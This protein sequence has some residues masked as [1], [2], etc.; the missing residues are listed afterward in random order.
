MV[1]SISIESVIRS[2]HSLL[3]LHS[4][5][6]STPANVPSRHYASLGDNSF[7][8]TRSSSVVPVS[9]SPHV[10]LVHQGGARA[11]FSTTVTQSNRVGLD[12]CENARNH[13]AEADPELG[14]RVQRSLGQTEMRL[15][16]TRSNAKT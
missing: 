7:T 15:G 10:E 5:P 12:D 4:Q 9:H 6:S 11:E 13:A 1:S 8:R 16:A 3:S 14:I 2:V